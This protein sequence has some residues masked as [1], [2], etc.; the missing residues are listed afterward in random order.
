M[1][2]TLGLDYGT[3]SVRC[4][5]VDTANGAELGT[6]VYPFE[7]GELGIML[8]PSDHNLARQ[9]PADYLKGI[10]KTIAGAMAE[11]KEKVPGFDAAHIIGIGVDTTGSTPIPVDAEGQPLAL[12]PEFKDNLNAQ[13]WLWKDHTGHVEAAEIT[14]LAVKTHPEYLAK[15]GGT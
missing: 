6:C 2:Y 7:T 10:E 8:D 11:A 15:C 9:S 3:N 1:P 13:A 5:L 14:A 4:V 12:K